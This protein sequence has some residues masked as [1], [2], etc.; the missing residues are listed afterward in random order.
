MSTV[1]QRFIPTYVG[2]IPHRPL[3]SKT[4]T[5]HPHIRGV[6]GGQRLFLTTCFR[7][8]PTYVGLM[9]RQAYICRLPA[10]HPHIRGVNFRRLKS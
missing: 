9:Q 4:P 6:N 1:I 7:F 10:V 2:L 3:R 8:I 5:V